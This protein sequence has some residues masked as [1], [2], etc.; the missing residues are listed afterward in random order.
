MSSEFS[1]CEDAAARLFLFPGAD[2]QRIDAMLAGSK[3]RMVQYFFE[4]CS[5]KYLAAE[6]IIGIDTALGYQIRNCRVQ[7]F[8]RLS[9]IY[10]F[11]TG[12]FKSYHQN[13]LHPLF[14]FVLEEMGF[15]SDEE[16]ILLLWQQ[17]YREK[18]QML[19]KTYP[20]II[21]P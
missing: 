5:R 4:L 2:N 6:T 19:I 3:N 21:L 17:F 18:L 10:T 8:S 9:V 13:E 7:D 11:M 20:D 1:A 12:W 15:N 14:P 16:R